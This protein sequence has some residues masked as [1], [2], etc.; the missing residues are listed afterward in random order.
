MV[1]FTCNACGES[2]KKGQVEKHVNMCR[3]CEY[4]SCMDC[5]KDFW[6]ENYKSH[7]KCVSE[8]Q[9]YG[10]KG[11]EART[12]KGDV[13]QQEWIQK[14]H[15]AIEKPNINP[16]VR[17]I[18]QQMY[19][20]DNI[21]RKKGKFQNWMNNSLKIHNTV[22]QDQV[23]DIFSEATK[24]GPSEKE[25]KPQDTAGNQ[26]EKNEVTPTLSEEDV[27][28][29]EGLAKKK[30][31]RE[32]K[33]RR[34]V[35][36]EK[37]ELRLQSQQDSLQPL[38]VKKSKKAKYE[39]EDEQVFQS[40]CVKVTKQKRRA[41]D[42]VEPEM[43]GSGLH[44][45]E[46]AGTKPRAKRC[47]RSPSE[48]ESCIKIKRKNCPVSEENENEYQGKFN[49]KGTI[50]AVL[51]QAPDHEISIKKLRKKVLA[52]YYAVTG[53]QHKSEVEILALFNKKVN[54]N[55]TFK[56]LKEKVKLLK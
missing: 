51:R 16:K 8:D 56:V 55:P 25:E 30:S 45:E 36:K 5:G 9:K 32:R 43:N 17:D 54:S 40:R 50:K 6:G 39:E 24:K 44:S 29:T 48:E 47:K 22:L 19:S 53:D 18:L 13:K 10:G 20:F 49:W 27:A 3:H 26:C 52:Q 33:E 28:K 7:M 31:K 2:V 1:V 42:A 11:Y 21:P 23:W 34:N 35:K 14:I 4:L 37:K 12:H 15:E 41:I 38:K 46:P